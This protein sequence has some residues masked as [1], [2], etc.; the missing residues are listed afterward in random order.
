ML[1]RQKLKL[2]KSFCDRL[3]KNR[4]LSHLGNYRAEKSDNILVMLRGVGLEN[5]N[6]GY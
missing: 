4:C 6:N 3:D 5:G 2:K 1:K